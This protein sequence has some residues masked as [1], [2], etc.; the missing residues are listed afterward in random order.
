MLSS[1]YTGVEDGH[2]VISTGGFHEEETP[3]QAVIREA[4]S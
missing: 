1:L 3:I 2:Y 4:G